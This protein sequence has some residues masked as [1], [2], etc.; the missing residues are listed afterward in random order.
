MKC[1]AQK[2]S[3]PLY[4]LDVIQAIFKYNLAYLRIFN[5][6]SSFVSDCLVE[7]ESACTTAVTLTAWPAFFNSLKET[8]TS[9][10]QTSKAL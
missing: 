6:I 4:F 9:L 1:K 3:T 10:S 5:S 7:L 2:T 8:R